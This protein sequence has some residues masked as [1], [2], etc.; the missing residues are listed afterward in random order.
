LIIDDDE[1]LCDELA[2]SLIAEGY[3][4]EYTADPLQGEELIRNGDYDTILLDY[5]MPV[6]TGIDILQNLKT[7]NIQKRIVFITGRP[8]VEQALRQENLLSLVDG[9]IKKPIDFERLLEI[10]GGTSAPV[11]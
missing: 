3:S 9:I 6:R 1:C 8:S 5:K 11:S 2:E 7:D 4:V 10:I